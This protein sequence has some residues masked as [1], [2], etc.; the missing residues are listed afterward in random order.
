M[1]QWFIVTAHVG[2]YRDVE[3]TIIAIPGIAE[4][5][6]V[7]TRVKV[8]TSGGHSSVPPAH[9]VSGNVFLIDLIPILYFL[10]Y[11]DPVTSPR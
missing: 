8:S 5:G 9:T 4:K 10:E 11:R 7:D 6:L 2:V 1:V 3:G